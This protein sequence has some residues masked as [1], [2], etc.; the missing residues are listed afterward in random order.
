MAERGARHFC[1]RLCINEISEILHHIC[2]KKNQNSSILYTTFVRKCPN[3]T[4][5]A[6]IFGP[7]TKKL[8]WLE[9][10]H[11]SGFFGGNC[12][13]ALSGCCA[14][15]VLYALEIDRENVKYGL[16]FSVLATITSGLVGVSPQNIF[17]TTCREAPVITLV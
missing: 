16:K 6:E 9:L 3:F 17:R 1:Q 15:K 11:P 13:S 14:L 4:L 7:Q 10:S 5:G 2:P 12:I 8:Y